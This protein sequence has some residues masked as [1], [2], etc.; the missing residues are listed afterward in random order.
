MWLT[1]NEKKVLKLLVDNAKLS[2]TSI[3]HELNISSQA[4]G[5]IRK[6]LE[7]EVIKKY[8]VELDLK[9]LDLNLFVLGRCSIREGEDI[10]LEEVEKRLKEVAHNVGIFKLFKGEHEYLFLSLYEDL[11]DLRKFIENEHKTQKVAKC[12]RIEEIFEVPVGNMLKCSF[13]EIF[14]EAIDKLGTKNNK[15]DLD[16]Q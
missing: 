8:T 7:E 12:I 11:D 5:K 15:I 2:D 1:K 16:N 3:A 14:T 9:K 13:E 6:K 10:K 4:I